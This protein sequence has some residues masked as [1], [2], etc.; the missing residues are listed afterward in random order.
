VQSELEAAL[1]TLL[2]HEVRTTAAGRTDA[3]VHALGQVVSVDVDSRIPVERLPVALNALLPPDMGVLTAREVTG[4]FS[5]VHSALS[6]TYCY[7]IWTAR[8]CGPFLRPYVY[9]VGAAPDVELMAGAGQVLIGQ[10]DFRAFRA[11]GSSAKTTVRHVSAFGV[12]QEGPL[13]IL[14]VTANGFLYNMV[15]IIAGSLIAVGLG[16]LPAGCLT[17]ALVSGRR[18]DL[19]ATA[20]ATGLWLTRVEYPAP[21]G[22]LTDPAGTVGGLSALTRLLA[23]Y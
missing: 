15:R 7:A 4:E 1:V 3:G 12:E 19:G 9:H 2:G 10:H 5:A 14:R 20:P 11:S 6:K 13:L 23:T 18:S 8:G 21:V 22:V 16:R 17:Q